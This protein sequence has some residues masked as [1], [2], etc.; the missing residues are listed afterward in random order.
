MDCINEGRTPPA[1]SRRIGRDLCGTTRVSGSRIKVIAELYAGKCNRVFM[2]L[3]LDY[4]VSGGLG[5]D[6]IRLDALKINQA[7]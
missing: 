5:H 3:G 6:H 2:L 7:G 4:R 1:V